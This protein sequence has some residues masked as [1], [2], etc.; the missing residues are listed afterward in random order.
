MSERLRVTKLQVAYGSRTV[1]DIDELQAA[2]GE[3]VV[4]LGGAGSGKSTLSAALAGALPSRG[5]VTIDS[6]P[7]SGT[8]SERRRQ[9]IA[10][11]LRDGSRIS[12]CTVAEALRIAARGSNRD[13]LALARFNQLATRR[14]VLAQLLSGG[15]QQLLRVAAAWC[16]APLVL[17]LDSPTV[18]LAADA[19]DGVA[20]LARAEAERG[21]TVIWL[22]QDA[23][24]AP[25]PPSLALEHGRIKKLR[26]AG[27]ATA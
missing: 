24:A 7:L 21:A 8:P 11:A 9:G 25:A 1:L 22:E 5:E 12:G 4:A 27:P 15:E 2:A 16:A 6:K 10:V 17:V 20:A 19:A 18:G 14:T 3:L 13:T 23:R 26:S